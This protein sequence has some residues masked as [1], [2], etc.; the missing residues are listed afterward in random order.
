MTVETATYI[1]DLDPT[2]PD[3]D[4]QKYEGDSGVQFKYDH[5]LTLRVFQDQERGKTT[6][7]LFARME[8]LSATKQYKEGLRAKKDLRGLAWVLEIDINPEFGSLCQTVSEPSEGCG[9]RER[10]GR[11]INIPC[12]DTGSSH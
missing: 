3:G 10:N 7:M 8:Y 6:D 11:Q 5:P 12:R 9:A 1:P 2:N 4:S